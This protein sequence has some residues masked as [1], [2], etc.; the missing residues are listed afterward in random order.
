MSKISTAWKYEA[1]FS[2]RDVKEVT[3]SGIPSS[4]IISS[5]KM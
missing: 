1:K 4:R 5:L 3:L 2:D